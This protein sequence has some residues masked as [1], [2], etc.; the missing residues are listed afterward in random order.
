MCV[1]VWWDWWWFPSRVA[2]WRICV[3]FRFV[4]GCQITGYFPS[5][6]RH[7][8][9]PLLPLLPLLISL[10]K[11][12]YFLLHLYLALL[13]YI[14]MLIMQGSHGGLVRLLDRVTAALD[15]RWLYLNREKYNLSPSLITSCSLLTLFL[16]LLSFS[17]LHFTSLNPSQFNSCFTNV[18]QETCMNPGKCL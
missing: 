1:C 2:L 10:F 12:T 18:F 14:I 17:S 15:Y 3:M 16:S 4:I 11:I 6:D 13:S 5:E 9:V 8:L 7:T